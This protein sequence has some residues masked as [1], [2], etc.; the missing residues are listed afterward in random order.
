ME[1]ATEAVRGRVAYPVLVQDELPKAA[2]LGRFRDEEASCL[3]ATMGFWQGVDVPGPALSMVAIDRVPFPRPDE[4]LHAAR[5]QRAGRDGFT[6]VDVPRA[7]TLLAQGAGRLIRSSSDRGVV[8]VL[9][10]RLASATYRWDLVR[11]LP[12]MRRTRRR[13]DV[14]AFF[15]PRP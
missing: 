15:S 7:A 12:P 11:A 2:L 14:T 3:F 8:A 9:D 4:P 10:R 13:E 5:R 1:A 6:T